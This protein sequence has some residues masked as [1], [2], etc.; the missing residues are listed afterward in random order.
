[1]DHSQR[2]EEIHR[3]LAIEKAYLASLRHPNIVRLIGSGRRGLKNDL[4]PFLVVEYLAG[5]TLTSLISKQKRGKLD[6]PP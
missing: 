2:V 6:M 1:S 4:E 3:Q 5:G